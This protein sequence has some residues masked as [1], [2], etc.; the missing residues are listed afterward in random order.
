MLQIWKKDIDIFV[1]VCLVTLNPHGICT[2]KSN[3][4]FRRYLKGTFPFLKDYF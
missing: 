1:T 2:A 3:E 4:Y